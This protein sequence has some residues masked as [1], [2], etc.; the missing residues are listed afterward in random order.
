[1]YIVKRKVQMKDHFVIKKFII[2]TSTR[3]LAYKYLYKECF[4]VGNFIAICVIWST[5][6]GYLFINNSI[7][8]IEKERRKEN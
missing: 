3:T 5:I 1:M 2:V 7:F 4:N 8:E 6:I